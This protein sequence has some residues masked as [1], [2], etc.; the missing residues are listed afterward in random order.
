MPFRFPVHFEIPKHSYVNARVIRDQFKRIQF[1]EHEVTRN[2]L[3]YI[4]RNTELPARARLEAQ[5][6]LAAM[7]KY[8]AYNQIK[9]RC[10]ATGCAKSVISD[11]KLNRTAFRDR[12]R[13]GVIPGVKVASW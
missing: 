4:S 1:A 3:K 13:A 9:N 5:L 12:A 8:T 10:V 11:F 2:A 6:Q 7:P